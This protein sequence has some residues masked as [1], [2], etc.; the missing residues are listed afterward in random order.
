MAADPA[1]EFLREL[2]AGPEIFAPELSPR[3]ELVAVFVRRGDH[4]AVGLLDVKTKKLS[5]IA[6]DEAR[7]RR[8]WWDSPTELLI[9][10]ESLDG[11]RLGHALLSVSSLRSERVPEL[12]MNGGRIVDALPEEPGMVLVLRPGQLGRLDLRRGAF[13]PVANMLGGRQQVWFDRHRRFRASLRTDGEGQ[14]ELRWRSPESAES[15]WQTLTFAPT[16]EGLVPAG[17]DADAR[18]LWALDDTGT[19]PSRVKRE[20]ANTKEPLSCGRD[21]EHLTDFLERGGVR[22]LNARLGGAV[23]TGDL[24]DTLSPVNA[25]RRVGVPALHLF[26]EESIR[27]R[28]K[29]DGREVRDALRGAKAPARCEMAF[30]YSDK[31][32]APLLLAKESA[33]VVTKMATF[34]REAMPGDAGK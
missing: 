5:T 15:D 14:R 33:E 16:E 4:F 2:F 12:A 26:D 25:A 30:S 22:T 9:E 20:Q 31:P 34:L 11:R 28:M 32:K 18:T 19:M 27:G 1:P 23:R 24:A 13:S 6:L 17:Y 21:L 8:L 3:G 29:E 10:S 7:P